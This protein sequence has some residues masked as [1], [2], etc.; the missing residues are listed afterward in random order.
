MSITNG[1]HVRLKNDPSRS[2]VVE[3]VAERSGRTTISISFADGVRRVP[4]EQVE[5]VPK[6]LEGAAELIQRGIVYPNSQEKLLS[7]VK[8]SGR[9]IDIFS[10]LWRTQTRRFLLINSSR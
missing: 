1:S 10:I 9:L 5:L 4:F 6:K 2:G 3:N 7:H 8:L